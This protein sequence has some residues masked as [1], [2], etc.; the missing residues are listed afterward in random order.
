MILEQVRGLPPH[1]VNDTFCSWEQKCPK[2]PKA[3]FIF[4]SAKK[5]FEGIFFPTAH[6]RIHAA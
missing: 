5:L 1:S 6:T 4:T 2:G 3:A